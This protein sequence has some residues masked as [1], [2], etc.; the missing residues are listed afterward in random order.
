[1]KTPTLETIKRD[2]N[3]LIEIMKDIK[4]IEQCKDI[5]QKHRLTIE[6]N[7]EFIED[8]VK[9]GGTNE[10]IEWIRVEH[11]KSLDYIYF[12]NNNPVHHPIY[13]DVWTDELDAEFIS[14][15]TI[16]KLDK[17]YEEGIKWIK[18]RKEYYKRKRG[19]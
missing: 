16:E 15:T 6:I 10:D 17:D 13:F 19:D 4:T 11:Y 9:D 5:E 7:G 12:F 1:M 2:Y 3:K 18:E 8:Y 14:D